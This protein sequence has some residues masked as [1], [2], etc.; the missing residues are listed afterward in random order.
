LTSTGARPLDEILVQ[1]VRD[2][3][4]VDGLATRDD[5]AIRVLV[6]NYHDDLVEAPDT[7]VHLSIRVPA[8]FGARARLSHLRVDDA[9]GDAFNVWLEQGAPA[10]PSAQQLA[11]LRQAMDPAALAPE[12]IRPVAAD[13]TL[14]VDFDLPRFGIS[15]VTLTSEG[16]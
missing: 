12:S 10:S 9:H 8:T 2:Q 14:S 6:W 3:A 11:D 1:S 13:G 16:G 15:L 7:S 5:G 4:D